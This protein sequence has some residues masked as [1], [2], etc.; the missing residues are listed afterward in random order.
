MRKVKH[1]EFI[2]SSANGIDYTIDLR[3]FLQNKYLK[4]MSIGF[5]TI[6]QACPAGLTINLKP[7]ICST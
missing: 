6:A 1:D 2:P 5:Y 3:S 4:N 7:I